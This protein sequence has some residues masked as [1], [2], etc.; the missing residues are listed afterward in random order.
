KDLAEVEAGPVFRE[1][2]ALSTWLNVTQW[3]ACAVFKN[4]EELVVLWIIQSFV[5]LHDVRVRHLFKDGHLS[6]H[7]VER[8][9]CIHRPHISS[10]MQRQIIVP[11]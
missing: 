5:E 6:P 4:K 10:H 3:S 7:K 9:L 8:V 1:S 11:L 2:L